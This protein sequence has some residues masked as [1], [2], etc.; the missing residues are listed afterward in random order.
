MIGINTEPNYKQFTQGNHDFRDSEINGTGSHPLQIERVL[1]SS[2]CEAVNCFSQ[3][4]VQIEVRV[5][6]LGSVSLSLCNDC[7]STLGMKSNEAGKRYR[8]KL[9]Y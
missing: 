7:V 6:H 1:K 8:H 3:A 5:G 4:A 2:I 9:P